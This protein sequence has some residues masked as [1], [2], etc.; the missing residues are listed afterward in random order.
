MGR[1]RGK[2]SGYGDKSPAVEYMGRALVQVWELP[3]S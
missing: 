3:R 1:R 2:V